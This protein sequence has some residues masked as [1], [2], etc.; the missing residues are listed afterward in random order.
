VA[1]GGLLRTTQCGYESALARIEPRDR[2]IL[3]ASA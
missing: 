2:F 1:P 3:A